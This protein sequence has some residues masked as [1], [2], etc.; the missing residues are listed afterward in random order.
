MVFT[1]LDACLY[2][3]PLG[4]TRIKSGHNCN[5]LYVGIAEPTPNCLASYDAVATA[6]LPSSL[7]AT[8]TGLPRSSGLSRC[9]M[10]EKKK[11]PYLY[12]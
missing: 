9:S 8:A 4:G 3:S 2:F 5:A 1:S 12:G 10:L 7:D 6:P 11:H